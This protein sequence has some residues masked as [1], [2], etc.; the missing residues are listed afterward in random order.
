MFKLGKLIGSVLVLAASFAGNAHATLIT[1]GSFEESWTGWSDTCVSGVGGQCGAGTYASWFSNID[2]NGK[3]Y[4]YDNDGYGTLSQTFATTIG[5]QYLLS[6]FYTAYQVAGNQL[7]FGTGSFADST[8]LALTTGWQES[9]SSF[10]ATQSNTTLSF[11]YQTDP[12]T[13]TLGLD[14]IAVIPSPTPEPETYAMLLA[15]LGL[16]GSIARR[17]KQAKQV[18][19]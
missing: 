18:I 13:G 19:A 5:Q 9:T 2:G 12:G 1:N 7:S 6:F 15:G 11:F 3:F 16:M 14:K 17:K 10:V 8:F 4:G